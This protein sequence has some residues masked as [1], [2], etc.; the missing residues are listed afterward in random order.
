MSK[1]TEQADSEIYEDQL[2]NFLVNVLTGAFTLDLGENAEIDPED[3]FEVL[4]GATAA[5][6]SISSLCEKSVDA[7]SGNDV[8][9]H[10]RTKF[11]PETAESTGNTLLQQDILK[12]LP[13]QAEV[14]ADLHLRPYYGDE[15][16]TDGLYYSEAKA[17]TAAFHAC[18][19]LY[20]RVNN[21]TIHLG[22]APS[23]RRR[24]R[25]RCP[26]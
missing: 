5:G 6:T 26:R 2:L 7:P 20:A 14:V 8:L 18:A 24:H 21:E 1:Q 16:E 11:D 15:D 12:T 22:G 3:I 25:Q 4:G 9:Y 17:G 23:H 10:L 19:T 13:Q